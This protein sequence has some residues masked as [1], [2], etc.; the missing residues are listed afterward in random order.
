MLTNDD[1]PELGNFL[2]CSL[3]QDWE[4][5]ADSYRGVVDAELPRWS[6]PEA[7]EVASDLDQVLASSITE[8]ELL[9]WLVDVGC[10]VTVDAEGY[11]PR[12]F[13]QMVAER[14]QAHH[15]RPR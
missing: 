2:G 8:E 13:L 11:T 3:H 15:P 6:G 14:L 4:E 10:Y 9:K 1:Y 5:T 12:S 7:W